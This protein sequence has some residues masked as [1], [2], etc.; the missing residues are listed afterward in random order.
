MS[1]KGGLYLSIGIF[2]V[3]LYEM[4]RQGGV[5]NTILFLVLMFA[6]ICIMSICFL[7]GMAMIK[8]GSHE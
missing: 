6:P 7:I 3:G 8:I 1:D 2:L 4:L 5:S